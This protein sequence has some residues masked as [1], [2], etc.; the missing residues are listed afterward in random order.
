MHY[1]DSFGHDRKSGAAFSEDEYRVEVWQ[2]PG[3]RL[4]G[5]SQPAPW[6]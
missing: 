6:T 5:R 3:L 1:A 2:P 4:P